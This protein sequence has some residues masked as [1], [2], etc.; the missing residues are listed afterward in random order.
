VGRKY[1]S[2]FISLPFRVILRTKFEGSHLLIFW[3][4]KKN[5]RFFAGCRMTMWIFWNTFLMSLVSNGYSESKI[6]STLKSL[7]LNYFK[8][9][10]GYNQ[11][12]AYRETWVSLKHQESFC[13]CSSWSRFARKQRYIWIKVFNDLIDRG[14]KRVMLIVSDDFPG[15]SKAIETLFPYADHQLCL[16]HL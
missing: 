13:L 5:R 4:E 11:K 8:T 12:I 10:Y 7:G 9:T 6:N 15:I 16:V 3:F 2:I 14:L 1:V